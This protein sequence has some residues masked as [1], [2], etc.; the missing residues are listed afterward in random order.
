LEQEREWTE[1]VWDIHKERT[2]GTISGLS[3]AIFIIKKYME[4]EGMDNGK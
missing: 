1:R 2:Q 3:A 4:K